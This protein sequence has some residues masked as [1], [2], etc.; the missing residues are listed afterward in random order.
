MKSRTTRKFWRLFDALP[1][2]VQ[3][4]ARR[5]YE[6]FRADPAH[7]GLQFKRIS[8]A[9]PWYSV[10]IGLDYRAIGLLDGDTVTWHWIGHH[11]EYERQI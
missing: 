8:K 1:A 7:P 3:E 10:R 2:D 5:S 9:A 6:Q 4:H 11:D